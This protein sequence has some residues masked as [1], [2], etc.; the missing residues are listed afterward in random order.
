MERRVN[1]MMGSCFSNKGRFVG[2]SIAAS[3]VLITLLTVLFLSSL[4]PVVFSAV[5]DTFEANVTVS[6]VGPVVSNV[7]FND[8]VA[9]VHNITLSAES[10]TNLIMCN[11]TITDLNGYQDV[12]TSGSVNATF[13]HTSSSIDAADNTNVHYTN[14]SCSF[15]AGSGTAVTAVCTVM[16]HYEATNGTWICNISAKDG[17]NAVNTGS[18]TNEVEPLVALTVLETN[19]SFG[20]LSN[21]QNSSTAQ[22]TNITNQGNVKIDVQVK[23]NTDMT[24]SGIGTLGVTNISFNTTSGNYDSMYTDGTGKI[25]TTGLQTLTDFD[26]VPSG[27]APFDQGIDATN[28]TYWSIQIPQAVKGTC[29]N[30]ITVAAIISN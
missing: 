8:T 1:D 12:A 17:S 21:G 30:T 6:N 23:G 28:L 26:L 13:Y 15:I 29:N 2:V 14:T 24:C 11:A 22:S 16:F 9:T 25:L 19:I 3:A 27:I 4:T 5:D 18:T 20:S 10:T 7:F